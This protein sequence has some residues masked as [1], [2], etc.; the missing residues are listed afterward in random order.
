M[1][2]EGCLAKKK[3]KEKYCNVLH[4]SL[5]RCRRGQKEKN[6]NEGLMFHQTDVLVL[7]RRPHI[8]SGGQSNFCGYNDIREKKLQ[9]ETHNN[10]DIWKR[11]R[12]KKKTKRKQTVVWCTANDRFCG[13]LRNLINCYAFSLF[14]FPCIVNMVRQSSLSFVL[15]F[16]LGLPSH[17]FLLLLN[18]RFVLENA[19]PV[20]IQPVD[21]G[22]W[23][24]VSW[25]WKPQD[26]SMHLIAVIYYKRIQTDG[27]SARVKYI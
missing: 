3:K 22:Q 27:S 12:Q 7:V 5:L 15:F 23:G 26:I 10:D 14:L 19:Q 25:A 2:N 18:D 17:S 8:F 21:R 13:Q 24:H 6:R 16:S 1:N 4:L 20:I 9:G 11:E